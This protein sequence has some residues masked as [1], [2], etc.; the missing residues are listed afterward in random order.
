[1]LQTRGKCCLI[2]GALGGANRANERGRRRLSRS[3]RRGADQSHS[4]RGDGG[5]QELADPDQ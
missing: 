1:M 4:G 5:V 3:D 2:S